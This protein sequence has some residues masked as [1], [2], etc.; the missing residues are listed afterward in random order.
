MRGCHA[1]STTR[2]QATQWMTIADSAISIGWRSF[3]VTGKLLE[4]MLNVLRKD[5]KFRR[6]SPIEH[7]RAIA[8]D[9]LMSRVKNINF[10]FLETSL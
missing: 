1:P 6:V 2:F 5:G 7:S 3:H 4:R 10:Y 9:N 8:R